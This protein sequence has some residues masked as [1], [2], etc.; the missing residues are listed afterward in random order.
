MRTIVA[1]VLVVPL[2]QFCLTLGV[3]LPGFIVALLLAWAPISLRT[4]IAGVFGGV[5]GVAIAVGW[6]YGVFHIVIGLGSFTLAPFL[7][8]TVPLLVPIYNDSIQAK[9]VAAARQAVLDIAAARGPGVTQDMAKVT[10]TA[11][12][13]G[14]VGQVLGLLLAVAWFFTK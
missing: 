14:A 1:Y 4:K 7:A 8:S 5:S 12:A 9:R 2:V 6:G 13:S 10:Q 3:L 11:H